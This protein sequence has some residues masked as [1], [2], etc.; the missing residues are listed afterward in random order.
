[1][2]LN[3]KKASSGNQASLASRPPLERMSKLHAL[4]QAGLYPNCASLAK[5]F[6]ISKKTAQR[7]LDFM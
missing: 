7:D 5:E 1:M 3:L 6:E 2:L 4:L